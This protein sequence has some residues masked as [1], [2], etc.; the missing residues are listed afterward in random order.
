[1]SRLSTD[2][3]I[4]VAYGEFDHEGSDRLINRISR[5]LETA[6][7]DSIEALLNDLSSGA[8][9]E[10]RAVDPAMACGDCFPP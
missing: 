7:P 8:L 9:G 6:P 5:H 1:M 2:D 3:F 10:F 4:N